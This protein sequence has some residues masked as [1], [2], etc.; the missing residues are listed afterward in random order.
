MV[1]RSTPFQRTT[2]PLT[3]SVPFTVSSKAKSPATAELGIRPE[4]VGTGLG[5][6]FM[7][8]VR[9]LEVPPPGAG[10]NTVTTAVPAVVMSDARM[11]A[12]S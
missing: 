2:E 5:A 3:K 7:V 6:G 10:L 1:V 12:V 9:P 11:L 8:K 4:A